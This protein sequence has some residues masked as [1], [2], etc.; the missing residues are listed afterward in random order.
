MQERPPLSADTVARMSEE[1]LGTPIGR[2]Q[3]EAV[4]ALLG[5]LVSEMA[6]M[7]AMEVGDTEPA[8]TYDASQP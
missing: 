4:A 1:L 5:G 8:T 6:P 3:R 2:Q 7:R